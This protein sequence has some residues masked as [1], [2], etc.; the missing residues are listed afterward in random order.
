MGREGDWNREDSGPGVN[1]PN[2]LKEILKE[3]ILKSNKKR[4]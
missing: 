4:K 2:R 3:L 1:D